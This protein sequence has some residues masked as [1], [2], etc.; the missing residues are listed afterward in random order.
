[1]D[2][3]R[4]G[5]LTDRFVSV[6]DQLNRLMSGGNWVRLRI[7]DLNVHHVNT[8]QV[9]NQNGPLRMSTIADHLGS[10]QS[11]ATNVVKKLVDRK[12]LNRKS[13]PD[14]RRVVICEITAM[15]RLIA[16]RYLELV[17]QRATSMA[18]LWDE[19]QLESVVVSLEVF[20]RDEA[21]SRDR[22]GSSSG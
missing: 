16:D 21:T 11:H 10:T 6:V 18:E 3:H 5:N 19:E 4:R 1:M 17:T 15:G 8:L 2:K 22:S 7:L 14:D 13:D 20:C 9:L 12:Y